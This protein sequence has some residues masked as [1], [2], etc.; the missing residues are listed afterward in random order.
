MSLTPEARAALD[1]VAN[2]VTARTLESATLDF[3]T[4]GRSRD[5]AFVGLAEASACFA[6]GGG[7]QIV[8]GV[9]DGAT[10]ARDL[11]DVELDVVRTQR[12][13][14]ELT[15]PSLV[16]TVE[17]QH[18]LGRRLV[19]ITVPRSPDVHQVRGRALERIGTSC[20][21]MTS[22]RIAVVVADR[23][24]DDWS[25][26]DSGRPIDEVSQPALDAVRSLLR[27]SAESERQSWARLPPRQLLSRLSL[28][29]PSRNLTNAG[30]ALLA[31]AGP[32]SIDYVHRRS[33]SGELT[34]NERLGEAGLLGLS[35][36]LDLID[37]R[38]DRTPINLP[39][40]QQIL[41]ADLPEGAVREALVNAV[42]HRDYGRPA[43]IQVEHTP[44][45][46]RVVS[47]GG[48][49]LGV[50]AD[51]VLTVNSRPRNPDLASALRKI[52]LAETAGVGV[53]RMYL[54]MAQL[55]HQPPTF[56]AT[57]D[58]VTVT[59][60]G[61]AP[62]AAFA[63]FLVTLS[64]DLRQDPDVVLVLLRLLAKRSVAAEAMTAVL[65]KDT[66]EVE[67]TL[68]RMSAPP[69]E[70]LERT[71]ESARSRMGVYRL[72]GHIIAAL[73]PAV[74]YRTR[75]GDESDRRITE[76][77]RET[78]QVNGRLV[79]TL[80]DVDTPTASRILADLVDRG[81]LVKTSEAQ[82][83]PGVTYGPGPRFP[84]TRRRSRRLDKD[85]D[86]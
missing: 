66:E 65:Q 20:E 76:V 10:R 19:V 41:V 50:T 32:G 22:Q 23:R 36:C 55:G 11:Q 49:V 29:A 57:P 17:Q 2:G 25:A 7:G 82:R 48:F 77:V 46:L 64:T 27:E 59:L 81:V 6:N 18:A 51:N 79:R 58:S 24:G 75:V 5:D 4:V 60:R 31:E 73:G 26:L 35:R 84:A 1:A 45:R 68:R 70:L 3:K 40:G 83:G 53:D 28:V 37:L 39:R 44:A 52:G 9:P 69:I 63:R 15:E 12:R 67:D 21:P 78:G 13:I 14:Y 16:V 61:G 33:R 74:T 43:T 56:D 30:A 62:N 86:G 85:G 71:R 47:P 38:R 72:R 34:V 54:D 42:A 8:V 80:L